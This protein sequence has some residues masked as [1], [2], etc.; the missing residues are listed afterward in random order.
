MKNLFCSLLTICSFT[1]LA[2]E[3][4]YSF[5][6]KLVYDYNV[7][8]ELTDMYPIDDVLENKLSIY[9]GNESLLGHSD[10]DF[11]FEGFNSSAFLITKEYYYDVRLN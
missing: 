9:I 2:Q 6:Q 7:S 1:L 11:L 3:N 4:T 5:N 10:N 8:D